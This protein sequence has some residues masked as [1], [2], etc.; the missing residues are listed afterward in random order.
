MLLVAS[1]LLVLHWGAAQLVC[2]WDTSY[3][4]RSREKDTEYR[5]RLVGDDG[6][7]LADATFEV[8]FESRAREGRVR[9]FSTDAEGDYCVR[10]AQESVIPYAYVD[11]GPSLPLE[12]PEDEVVDADA[13]P[14]V[15]CQEGDAGVPWNRSDEVT[16]T[17]EFRALLVAAALAVLV[18]IIGL[19]RPLRAIFYAGSALTASVAVAFAVLWF[20]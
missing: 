15:P 19:F 1:A 12:S 18:L 5:G 3:C 4:A 14:T 16:S 8:A 20:A 7:V 9:G 11:G 6:R 10:W 2:A 17:T 13:D